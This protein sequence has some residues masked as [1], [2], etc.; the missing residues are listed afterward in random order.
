MVKNSFMKLF[1]L[2]SNENYAHISEG[3]SYFS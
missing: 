1:V 3:N 2:S